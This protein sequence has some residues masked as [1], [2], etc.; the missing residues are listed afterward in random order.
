[1]CISKLPVLYLLLFDFVGPLRLYDPNHG[2]NITT[3]ITTSAI[4]GPTT[5]VPSVAPIDPVIPFVPSLPTGGD[6]LYNP[7]DY[8]SNTTVTT[9][10]DQT[11]LDA[12]SLESTG[13]P[14]NSHTFWTHCFIPVLSIVRLLS[15]MLATNVEPFVS[16]VLPEVC[17]F[18]FIL[19]FLKIIK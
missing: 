1:M 15:Q 6:Q 4:T 12:Q 19:Y 10:A 18:G 3:T 2:F 11:S 17:V 9:S 13:S 5:S 7:N 8:Y 16:I 14:Y